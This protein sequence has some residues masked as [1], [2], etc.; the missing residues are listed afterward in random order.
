MAVAGLGLLVGDI[1]TAG[2]IL[3]PDYATAPNLAFSLETLQTISFCIR[4]GIAVRDHSAIERLAATDLLII[5]HH[6]ALER[7]EL[8][9]DAIQAFAGHGEKDLLRYAAAAFRDLDD[10]RTA[11]LRSA[12]LDWRI[13]PLPLRP[14]EFATDVTL[15]YRNDCI[16]VGDLGPRARAPSI[17]R[18]RGDPGRTEPEPPNSLMVGIN[19]RV[20]GLVHFRYS[21]RLEAASTIRRLRSKRHLRV[22]IVSD[23]PH[24]ILSPL[25]AVLGVDF[26]LGSQS[27]DDRVRFLQYCRQ[28]GLKVAYVGDCR[29]DPRATA[30]AHVAISLTEDRITDMDRDTAPIRL[31][32]PRFTKLDELW[33][34]V[35]I[36]QRRLKVAHG[37]ALIPNLLCVAGAF[38]WGFTPFTSVVVTNLGIYAVYSRTASSIRSLE[39]QI[40]RPLNRR[41]FLARGKP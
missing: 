1:A 36:Y 8:E 30:E 4:H 15:V 41:L 2:A 6:F 33:E 27:P 34:I 25:A 9:V 24:A 38:A 20:A 3:Q 22:G 17:P 32:Q 26:Y 40:S 21:T 29:I 14:I 39:R 28:R 12:C 13:T 35:H 31:L 7:T 11:A 10:V 19:G 5:D 16:K 18:Y 37:Y 23:Q